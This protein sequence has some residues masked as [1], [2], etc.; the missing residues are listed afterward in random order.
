MSDGK[1]PPSNRARSTR[2]AGSGKQVLNEQWELVECVGQGKTGFVYKGVDLST[3]KPIGV[4]II[5]PELVQG[6]AALER[7]Q[8]E[9]E[10]ISNLSHSNLGQI[11]GYGGESDGA[12]YLI[13]EF[14]EGPSLT[15]I[16]KSE[17]KLH[18]QRALDIFIQICSGLACVHT[19]GIMH[20][21][22]RP[23]SVIVQRRESGQE[24]IAI[25]DFGFAKSDPT[26]DV[27]SEIYSL[28][29]LM[30]EALTGIPPAKEPMPV[31]AR[32]TNVPEEIDNIIMKC[33]SPEPMLRYHSASALR[34]DLD[35]VKHGALESIRAKSAR[36]NAPAADKNSLRNIEGDQQKRA[37]LV[38]SM[39]A[40]FV[41]IAALIA[42]CAWFFTRPAAAPTETQTTAPKQVAP[43]ATGA[44]ESSAEES[45]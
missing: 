16:I 41:M 25:V 36:S 5:R 2:T 28:G 32:N 39:L 26:Y 33:L 34:Q 14:V 11:Y 3:G 21:D 43:Q 18:H 15:S 45:R 13:M 35:S 8:K 37:M 6:Q 44:D 7:L 12:P 38:G 10:T 40:A 27:R 22:L 9:V 1:I 20:R 4:K 17:G 19:S 30:Y 31:R 23:S 42:G 29:S 24:R